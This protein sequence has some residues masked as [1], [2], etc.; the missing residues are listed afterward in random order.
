MID[1]RCGEV[2]WFL[3]KKAGLVSIFCEYLQDK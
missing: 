2:S 3:G 1:L